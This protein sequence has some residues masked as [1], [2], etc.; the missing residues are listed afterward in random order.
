M[1]P[2]PTCS[3]S[4][5][6]RAIP[7]LTALALL[8]LVSAHADGVALEVIP[9]QHRAAAELLPLL[10]PF[11][12]KDGIVKGAEDKLLVRTSQA[13]L[14][15]LRRLIAQLDRP[16]RRL[17][18]EVRQVS[19]DS[20]R[21]GGTAAKEGNKTWG[22]DRLDEADRLQQV[23]VTEGHEAL[24]D[25]G[26]QI[27]ISDFAVTLGREGTRI[28]QETR[29]AG[30]TTGFYAR[31]LLSGDTVTV[32]I[33]PYQAA[34]EGGAPPPAFDVQA[35]HTTV[36]GKL[37]EWITIGASTTAQETQED[38]VVTYSTTRRGEPDRL[39]LLR[40]KVAGP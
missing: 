13:N 19:G 35:L 22:T 7:W 14:A 37:G 25:V 24:I 38:D 20:A 26:R 17:T 39:I 4:I 12:D 5:C 15:E 11:V 2:I 23:Q 16:L 1:R 31:P 30:A 32:D 18:I 36:T 29:Y 34:L 9:L 8:C 3:V 40:V 27:P 10:Q 6:N 28:A 21:G 33:R